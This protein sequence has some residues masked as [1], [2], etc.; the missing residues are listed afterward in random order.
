MRNLEK[1]ALTVLAC[2]AAGVLVACSGKGSKGTR[3][4]TTEE[5]KVDKSEMHETSSGLLVESTKKLS[6]GVQEMFCRGGEEQNNTYTKTISKKELFKNSQGGS[7]DLEGELTFNKENNKILSFSNEN[8]DGMASIQ[9]VYD[10]HTLWLQGRA[11]IPDSIAFNSETYVLYDFETDRVKNVFEGVISIE[12][13]GI[14]RGAC[15]SP[16]GKKAYTPRVR[17]F[18]S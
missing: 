3:E 14:P 9:A 17:A 13:E 4:E 11:A 2:L 8:D 5:T 16:D 12:D 6:S 7:F 15:F 1:L 18:L 10:E